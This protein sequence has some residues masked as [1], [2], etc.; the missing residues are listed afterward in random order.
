[1][2]FSWPHFE[3]IHKYI[4]KSK[5]PDQIFNQKVC[6]TEKIDGSNLTIHLKK[7][8]EEWKII[9]IIGRSC[10]IWNEDMKKSY[11]NLSY[12][13]VGNMSN[14]V[15]HMKDFA[16]NVSNKLKVNEILITG[17]V[18]RANSKFVSWHPFGYTLETNEDEKTD[19]SEN[20]KIKFLT[21][22]IYKL[23]V[24]CSENVKHEEL[25]EKLLNAKTCLI[26][27]PPL[28]FV[29]IL[30]DGIVSLKDTMLYLSKDFEGVFIFFED[31]FD[32][33]KWKTGLHEEQPQVANI[34]KISFND[35]VSIECYNKLLEVYY[36]KP[37]KQKQTKVEKEKPSNV[38]KILS[39]DII[40]AYKR[41]FTKMESFKDKP[42]SER[43]TL[44][45]PMIKSV[46]DE[47]KTK[48]SESDMKIPYSLELLEKQTN[49]IVTSLIK[50]E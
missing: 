39:D 9:Q 27:P 50:K 43:N 15:D 47:I 13:S 6:I 49:L 25:K 4:A 42:V 10:P 14:L 17:E 46:L 12:G 36:N 38:M 7:I 28:M 23:F 1:M 11:I 41:E 34:E 30:K 22:E 20:T 24:D 2:T 37:L 48:Y 5:Y 29:G 40:T 31:C 32:G 16:I 3:N 19:E 44:I 45:L 8:D 26:F 33:V 21:Y 18:F 35:S